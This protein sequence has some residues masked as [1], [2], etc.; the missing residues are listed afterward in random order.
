M[1]KFLN[2]SVDNTLGGNSPSDEIVSSQKAVKEY[3][4]SA[5]SSRYGTCSTAAGTQAKVVVCA[6]FALKTGVSIRVKFTNAQTYNGAITLNVNSTGEISVKSIGT[7]N[8]V[9][10][11]WMAGEI[12]SFTYDGT[13]WLMEDGGVATTTY[14][15]YTKL[16]TSATSTSTSL[17]VTPASINNIAQNMIANCPVYSASATYAVGDR[18][19]YSYNVWQCNTAITTAEA[20]NEAHWTKID[21]IQTQID[22]IND[23]IGDVESLINAL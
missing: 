17:A 22:E 6:G 23:M 7:T 10:Y 18:V 12:V 15:G 8:A 14:Y 1:T 9:R 5:Q 21:D 3:V 16:A 11:C 4:D 2:I 20:W 19:R 13:N